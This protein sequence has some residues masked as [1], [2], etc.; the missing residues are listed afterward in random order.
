MQN[1]AYNPRNKTICPGTTI[2]WINKD[3]YAHRITSGTRNSPD[4]LL[5]SGNIGENETFSFTY[6]NV[7]TS[8]Y[9]CD[10]HSGMSGTITVQ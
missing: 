6:D 8:P 10:I 2:T 9:Y 4:G 3:S 1:T 7:G 5:D